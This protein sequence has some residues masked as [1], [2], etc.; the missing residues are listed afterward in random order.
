MSRFIDLTGQTFGEWTVVGD[1]ERR[2]HRTYWRVR[3]TCGNTA[4]VRSDSLRQQSTAR[5]VSCAASNRSATHRQ[6]LT[7]TWRSWQNM[8]S[9]CLYPTSPDFARYGGAGVT[10]DARWRDF[11]NFRADMGE[12]PEGHTLDRIDVTRGYGPDNCRWADHKTQSRNKHRTVYIEAHGRRQSL[13]DW[14]DELGILP[15][16][17]YKRHLAGWAPEDIVSPRKMSSQES[18][19]RSWEA[20]QSR[21]SAPSSE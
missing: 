17:L 13:S 21:R 3:C 7:P 8:R 16:T 15:V 11:E 18:G 9:R 4:M 10:I 5:C 2:G 20:R 6:T 19:R 12:R 1:P 14:A